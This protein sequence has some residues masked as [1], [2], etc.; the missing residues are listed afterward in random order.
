MFNATEH[1]RGQTFVPVKSEISS[2]IDIMS[3]KNPSLNSSIIF[4]RLS[5]LFCDRYHLTRHVFDVLLNDL[6]FSIN[7]RTCELYRSF[8]DIRRGGGNNYR[9][10]RATKFR[11]G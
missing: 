11:R 6:F 5:Q 1:I 10:M 4:T 2:Y 8:L 7:F 9:V 3:Q